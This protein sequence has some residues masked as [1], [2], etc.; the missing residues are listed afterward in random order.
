MLIRCLCSIEVVARPAKACRSDGAR[1]VYEP[2][3]ASRRPEKELP[4]TGLFSAS[5]PI[6]CEESMLAKE[7]EFDKDGTVPL[8]FA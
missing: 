6:A 4:C 3:L 5:E 2:S 1:R 8:L 7:N